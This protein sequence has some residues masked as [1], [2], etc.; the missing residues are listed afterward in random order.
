MANDFR[1]D[2]V[3]L[4][5]PISD[6]KD[7]LKDP[8]KEQPT[9]KPPGFLS[10]LRNP[11]ELILEESLPASLFQWVTGNTKKKQAQDA[12]NFL[13]RYSYLQN[14]TAYKEAE[15][16]YNKFGYLLDEDKEHKFD[17]GEIVKL[18]KQYPSVMGAEFVNMLVADPWLLALP[19]TLYSRLGRGI[20]NATRSAYKGGSYSSKVAKTKYLNDIKVGTTAALL[21]PLAF[22]TGLQ[23]GEKGEISLNRTTSETTFGATAGILI[24]TMLGGIGAIGSK[25]KLV[26]D[27]ELQ[28]AIYNGY[29]KNPATALELD[30]ETGL[31]NGLR[32]ARNQLISDNNGIV[33]R[34]EFVKT[35]NYMQGASNEINRNTR[36]MSKSTAFKTTALTAA[37]FGAIG[38][39]AQFLTEPD[40]KLKESLIG[41]GAGAGLYLG[42]RS[43]TKLFSRPVDP[44]LT[45]TIKTVEDGLIAHETYMYKMQS[46]VSQMYD[47]LVNLVPDPTE[48]RQIFHYVQGTKVDAN[49]NY[50]LAGRVI[51]KNDLTPNQLEASEFVRKSLDTMYGEVNKYGG[52]AIRGYR[53]NYLPILWDDFSSD[54]NGYGLKF[55]DQIT[56]REKNLY[57]TSPY[58][59]FAKR[60]VFDSINEGFDAGK[61]LKPGMDDVA[62][63]LRIYGNQVAKTI[64]T[65]QLIQFLNKPNYSPITVAITLPNGGNKVV[66]VPIFI[67]SQAD[68]INAQKIVGSSN[69]KFDDLYTRFEHPYLGEEKFTFIAKGTEKSMRM[70]FDSTSET[71]FT[72]AVFTLNMM[73]K[74]L[75][76]GF[77]F[78][79]AAALIESM[80]FA[81]VKTKVIGKIV[82]TALTKDKTKIQEMIDKPGVYLS[83]FEHANQALKKAG[84][85]DVTKFSQAS[86]LMIS[87]PEDAGLD[88]FYGQMRKFDNMLKHQFGIKQG[89][90]IEKVFKWFDRITWDR[91]Y[92]HAKLYTFLTHLN[93][94]IDPNK[95]ISIA[96]IYAKGAIAAQF[97]NDAFGGQNWMRLTQRVQTPILKSLSQTL[98]SPGSRGYMQLLMFAPD[99]TISNVRILGKSLPGFEKN[100]DARRMYSYYFAR[101]AIM[102]GTFGTAL[103]YIMSGH[104]QLENKDPTRIDMGDGNVLTFSKQLMEPFHWISDPQKTGLKKIGSLPR[105]VIE[106]LTNKKYLTTGWAPNITTKDDNAIEK[107]IKIGGKAGEKF[108]PIWLQSSVR[109][110]STQLE[111]N[112]VPS[113]T[114]ATVALDFVLGQLGHPRYKGPRTS[115]YKLGGLVRNPYET[116][117]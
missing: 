104:S 52:N 109:T 106:L 8:L 55:I 29:A 116:I 18:A 61:R 77:S 76:V 84:W 105:G 107:A 10:S 95:D 6:I 47:D 100:T 60:R 16:I 75:A 94:I 26:P 40:E 54:P 53:L 117:F 23:L 51:V 93:K 67:S 65:R 57:G 38:A 15:R 58:S 39:T 87:T 110:I 34:E 43:L 101:S 99:W 37:S 92:T 68:Y 89:A 69:K 82:K 1:V 27:V 83:E 88:R 3:N 114:A 70:L 13:K 81:G 115:K 50:S 41:F 36:N 21:T 4:K 25:A 80:F 56:Q 71:A 113:E 103:N 102:Y 64:A 73:M 97:T 30:P 7:P 35:F 66:R 90:N 46:S 72:S 111:A 108:L 17:F 5:D 12:L 63:L 19:S 112:K 78:F 9:Q 91:I 62:E 11:L 14:S 86:G 49:G 85:G 98:Y 96:Q 48:R 22:S 59:R 42:V 74:R 79:H 24:A 44:V 28:K 33:P 45:K 31:S 2:D 20:V 32:N